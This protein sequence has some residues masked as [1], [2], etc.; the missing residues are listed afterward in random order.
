MTDV[1]LFATLLVVALLLALLVLAIIFIFR[2]A[3][4]TRL[5]GKLR[6]EFDGVRSEPVETVLQRAPEPPDPE[7]SQRYI[8][9]M[10]SMPLEPGPKVTL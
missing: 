1:L 8:D 9:R 10:R 3:Y 6:F 5:S 4:G 2:L 7:A